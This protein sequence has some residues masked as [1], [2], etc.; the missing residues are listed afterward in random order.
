MDGRWYQYIMLVML[1]AGESFVTTAYLGLG[2]NL[3]DKEKNL[4]TARKLLEATPGIRVT[5]A[6]S[7]YITAPWGKTDQDDFLN[8]VLAI[9]TE[10]AAGELLE[11]VLNIEKRMGRVRQERWG[12]RLIDID[13]I[14]FG[15]ETINT[16]NL[17]VP[18]PYLKERAFVLIPLLEIAPT[19]VLPGGESVR[20][21][22]ENLTKNTETGCV[23]KVTVLKLT[24]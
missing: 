2:S 12:P 19:A 5:Q 14:L 4:A 23:K 3:G 21:I 20:A 8:Q 17:T 15:R 11:A 6:S 7:V 13:I 18:H 10:L 16:G 1:A 24:N 9:E 22:L